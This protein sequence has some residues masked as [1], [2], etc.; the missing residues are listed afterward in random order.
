M[1][2]QA[3]EVS[4]R[5][6]DPMLPHPVVI[7]RSVWENDDTFTLTLDLGDSLDGFRF[8]PGQFNMVY[9]Y[10]VGEAA[11]SISSDPAKAGTQAAMTYVRS[12]N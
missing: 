12:E 11:V 7:R 3:S 6:A 4:T 10:G 1:I 8:L 2:E 9:V 5:N